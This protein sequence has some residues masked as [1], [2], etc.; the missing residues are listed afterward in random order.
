MYEMNVYNI[1]MQ[2]IHLRDVNL[3]LLTALDALLT[4]C[5][6]TRAAHHL[7]LTQS[8]TSH[9]LRR[10]RELFDDPLLVRG[11][12]GMVLTSRAE[13]LSGPVRSGLLELQRAVYGE[14]IFKADKTTRAFSVATVDHPLMTGRPK[15]LQNLKQNAP[16][17]K[18][19]VVPFSDGLA[20][21]LEVGD[22]DLVL[23]GAE[24]EMVLALEKGLM[25]TLAIKEEFVCVARKD[26]AVL[27]NRKRLDLKAYL[28]LS[29]LL[30]STTARGPGIVD[31]VLLELGHKRRI[32]VRIPYFSGV[33]YMLEN[34]DLIATLP[35]S[36]AERGCKIAAL[37][38]YKPP[39][40][41][42]TSD[43]YIWWHERF[44]RDPGTVWFRKEI[45]QA[46]APFRNV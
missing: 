29:H 14:H 18:L 23:A 44:H 15:F 42:P 45:L 25:R 7:G 28:A 32:D 31:V 40:E 2:K 6:V 35:K 3:N 22:V 41:L 46:F 20:K 34:T 26:H 9:A 30:V 11:S 27:G 39:I 17:A 36:M 19:E 8:A 13:E 38:M 37:E 16:H 33:P 10:L 1:V 5:N 12:D 4:E 24:A 21:G 43:A